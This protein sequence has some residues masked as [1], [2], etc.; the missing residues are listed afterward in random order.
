MTTE[1]KAVYDSLNLLRKDANE[2]KM[3]ELSWVYFASQTRILT[4]C[5]TQ[6]LKFLTEIGKSECQE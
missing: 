4:N 1:Q 3:S 2:R 6:H 5:T